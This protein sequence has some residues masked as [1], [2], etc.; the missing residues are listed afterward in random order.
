M[1]DGQTDAARMRDHD[2]VASK[3]N[4]KKRPSPTPWRIV[5]GCVHDRDGSLIFTVHG[6][7]GKANAELIVERVNTGERSP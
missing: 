4:L 3:A 6:V 1:T 7:G 2:W 5:E